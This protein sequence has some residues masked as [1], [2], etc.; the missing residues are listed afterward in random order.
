MASPLP[1]L[2][3][4]YPCVRLASG[5]DDFGE[6]IRAAMTGAPN[7]DECRDLAAANS[8]DSRAEALDDLLDRRLSGAAA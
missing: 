7:P 6:A 3:G 4:L 2:E 5:V 8:W 1:G